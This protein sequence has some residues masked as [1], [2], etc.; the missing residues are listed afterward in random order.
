MVTQPDNAASFVLERAMATA[1]A[2]QTFEQSPCETIPL[3]CIY[4]S[5]DQTFECDEH[6]ANPLASKDNIASLIIICPFYGQRQTPNRPVRG[7]QVDRV[8]DLFTM[9]A[10]LITESVS[11][12]SYCRTN[13][14]EHQDGMYGGIVSLTLMW[15]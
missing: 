6:F 10:C 9:G 15:Q 4:Q 2:R 1:R 3:V 11:L 8:S 14:P 5:G 7:A 12:L 13:I